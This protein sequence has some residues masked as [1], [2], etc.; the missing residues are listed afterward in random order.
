MYERTRPWHPLEEEGNPECV[1]IKLN[2]SAPGQRVHVLNIKKSV[3][4]SLQM[5]LFNQILSFIQIPKET[6]SQ[7]LFFVMFL[8][9]HPLCISRK[10]ALCRPQTFAYTQLKHKSGIISH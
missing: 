2:V 7:L 5:N 6:D 10:I 8:A 3:P 4:V 9:V 1:H